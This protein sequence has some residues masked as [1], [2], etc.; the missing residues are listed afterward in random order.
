MKKIIIIIFAAGMALVL[1]CKENPVSDT[2]SHESEEQHDDHSSTIEITKLQFESSDFELGQM[3]MRAFSEQLQVVGNIHLPERNMAEVSTLVGGTV[4]PMDLIEGQWVA[5]DQVLFTLTIPSLIMLQEEYLVLKEQVAYLDGEY[6]RNKELS[7][8][9]ITTRKSLLKLES[10]LKTTKVEFASHAQKLK[11]YGLNPADIS[12]EQLISSLPIKAP[13]GGYITEIHVVRGMYL[14]AGEPAMRIAN[15]FHIHLELKVLEKDISKIK[16]GQQVEFTTQGD[17]ASKMMAEVYLI[18][19]MVNEDRMLNIHCHIEGAHKSSLKPG[20]YT[21]A[22]IQVGSSES[23]AIPEDAI[24]EVDNEFFALVQTREGGGVHYFE[25][26]TI[27]PG[28]TQDAYTVVQNG[29]DF[30]SEDLFLT[31]GAFML[32]AEGAG[33]HDH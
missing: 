13:I 9:N 27:M 30:K 5:K 31:K 16:V 19:A 1:G 20:M 24:V 22:L 7:A 26:K 23:F 4:G 18:D 32:L 12:P 29:G 15:N 8:E 11:L 14:D 25:K 2:H 17:A 3:S 33:G 21:N 6:A 10:E 28:V